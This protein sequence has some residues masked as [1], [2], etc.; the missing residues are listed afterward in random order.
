MKYLSIVL[1]TLLLVTSCGQNSTTETTAAAPVTETVIAVQAEDATRGDISRYTEL[2][3]NVVSKSSLEIMAENTGKIVNLTVEYGDTVQKDQV[4]AMID[5]S[6]PGMKYGMTELKAPMTGT[7]TA[8]NISEGG[9]AAPSMSCGTVTDLTDLRVTINIPEQYVTQVHTGDVVTLALDAYPGETLS[10]TVSFLSPTLDRSSK[11]RKAEITVD[12]DKE[13]IVGMYA[14]VSILTASSRDTVLVPTS[15][16]VNENGRTYVYT[17]SGSTV[18]KVE[19]TTG[20]YDNTST[21]IVSGLNGTES[22]VTKGQQQL[23]DGAKVS[24]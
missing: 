18:S 2:S 10:G 21:E 7:I 19:V 23:S 12:T 4:I 3:G 8:L 14:R 1:L 13:L 15:A 20:L 22:V 5:P 17:V 6:K 11:T 24:L 16:L 9:Y